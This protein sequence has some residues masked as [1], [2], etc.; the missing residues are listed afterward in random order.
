MQSK[1][2]VVIVVG[3]QMFREFLRAMLEAKGDLEV[4]DEVFDGMEAIDS[5]KK[6]CPNLLLL[7]LALPRL[8]GGYAA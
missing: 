7:D 6:N 3:P 2:K 8:S 4:A 1:E 5:V